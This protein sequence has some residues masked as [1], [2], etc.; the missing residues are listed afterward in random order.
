LIWHKYE[1]ERFY[2]SDELLRRDLEK[3]YNYILKDVSVSYP[4]ADIDPSTIIN[5][6]DIRL[7]IEKGTSSPKEKAF[8]DLLQETG[9]RIGEFLNLRIKDVIFE[10][11]HAKVLIPYGKTGS[12]QVF[13]LR[14][15]PT[16]RKYLEVHSLRENPDS[17]LWISDSPK[18]RNQPMMHSGTRKMVSKCFEKAG[19][20]KRCN[21]HWFR[22]SRATILAPKLTE[23]VLCKYMGWST[24]SKQVRRYVHPCV[25]QVEDAFL[26]M[27]DL[28][29]G[30]KPK[31]TTLK[32]VCGTVNPLEEKY[33]YRC[34]QPL[35]LETLMQEKEML[36][37]ETNKSI[38][39]LMEISKNPD[40]M[41]KFN[42]FNNTM[43]NNL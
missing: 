30:N 43:N 39:L 8:L 6:E 11:D 1:D 4:E 16:L 36:H 25:S 14:S 27:Y 37:S 10:K 22:H 17:F 24:G 29:N 28:T 3:L 9:A 38:Q 19:L 26:G 32:C 2:E 33:C 23:A 13:I 7:V 41:A 31:E 35:R 42:E 5:D 15:I 21:L 20:K 12:R 34:Y 40:L 18:T